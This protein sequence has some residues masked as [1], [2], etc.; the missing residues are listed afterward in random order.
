MDRNIAMFS[1]ISETV[2][3]IAGTNVFKAYRHL[4]TVSSP[5]DWLSGSA[6]H[7]SQVQVFSVACSDDDGL[8]IPPHPLPSECLTCP[9]NAVAEGFQQYHLL[10]PRGRFISHLDM[11]GKHVSVLCGWPV[12]LRVR[13][14][15][16]V[17]W[18]VA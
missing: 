9:N 8:F 18:C 7:K 14:N 6:Q 2:R 16:A 3:C 17:V 4:Y 13:K 15:V 5:K 10:E 1:V 11:P 12:R